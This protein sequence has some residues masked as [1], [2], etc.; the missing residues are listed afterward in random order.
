MLSIISYVI[1]IYQNIFK[2]DYNT[3]IKKIREDIIYK[4]LEDSR[5]LSKIKEYD[6]PFKE[7]I[8]FYCCL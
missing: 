1:G 2:I 3:D 6:R 8:V 4:I 7:S 5:S